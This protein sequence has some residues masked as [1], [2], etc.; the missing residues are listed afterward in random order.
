M[1]DAIHQPARFEA[2]NTDNILG[3]GVSVA[4]E[5]AAHQA[6]LGIEC[7]NEAEVSLGY[8][9]FIVKNSTAFTTGF[10]EYKGEIEGVGSA[11]NQFISG[12]KFFKPT[13]RIDE[14]DTGYAIW[15]DTWRIRII[16]SLASDVDGDF[17]DIQDGTIH[18]KPT[19]NQVDGGGRGYIALTSVGHIASGVKL[20]GD[21][22]LISDRVMD[23]IRNNA[24]AGEIKN[25][26][27][28]QGRTGGIS[29]IIQ[30]VGETGLLDFTQAHTGKGNLATKNAVDMDTA[31][32]LNKTAGNIT[33]TAGRKWAGETGANITETRTSANTSAVGSKSATQVGTG[34]DQ[35]GNADTDL[36]AL[37][38]TRGVTPKLKGSK[39]YSDDGVTV[40][41]STAGRLATGTTNK[42][43]AEVE[44]GVS[45]A[46][47]A[48][49]DLGALLQTRG[50]SPKAKASKI[51]S[52][53]GLLGVHNTDGTIKTFV[54]T[55]IINAL[56]PR[57]RVVNSDLEFWLTQETPNSWTATGNA[58]VVKSSTTKDAGSYSA[59][60]HRKHVSEVRVVL[61]TVAYVS[62]SFTASV[63]LWR[64]SGSGNANVRVRS[65]N[66]G[67]TQIAVYD[68]TTVNANSFTSSSIGAT[69][70]SGSTAFLEFSI[71]VNTNDNAFFVDTCSLNNGGEKLSNTGFETWTT[72]TTP[73]P[74]TALN[75]ATLAKSTS[76]FMGNYCGSITRA[77][78]SLTP[79]VKYVFDARQNIAGLMVSITGRLARVSGS[80]TAQLRV[81]ALSSVD[82]DLGSSAS[83]T[84]SATIYTPRVVNGYTLPSSTQKIELSIELSVN[85]D[86]W[87]FDTMGLSFTEV[88]QDMMSVEG[89]LIGEYRDWPWPEAD[90][91]F[92]W[93]LANGQVVNGIPTQDRRGWMPIGADGATYP[94]NET[95]GSATHNHGF[96][97]ATDGH[98][99]HGSAP[100]DTSSSLDSV[101][102]QSG[103]G[104]FVSA[105]YHIHEQGSFSPFTSDDANHAHTGTTDS[106]FALP[107]PWISTNWIVYIGS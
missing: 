57:N 22:G 50:A 61:Q 2:V 90:I 24:G 38:Q 103:T 63:K 39:V 16:V 87:L 20:G 59:L 95:G 1:S 53:D 28:V 64:Y 12:T 32:V 106:N 79:V 41:L 56:S 58:R 14:T 85:A 91:P 80:G 86:V 36:G 47:S 93:Y 8:R 37:L 99:Q 33:E 29:T 82:A 102:V 62:G 40:V 54:A 68:G 51:F 31:E 34:V 73:P 67:G 94:L 72:A 77:H 55:P 5:N 84:T 30:Y 27:I 65:L 23:V 26:A 89:N 19:V 100:F 74:W 88:A 4:V 21:L 17:D 97:T 25:T 52:D 70:P 96:T 75:G 35:A 46:A 10:I 98:H 78:A 71:A 66:S 105:D 81:R 15:F 45:Q 6:S 83:S 7:F 92:G 101:Q 44:T 107:V 69:T 49:T 104:E 76:A 9:W 18:I 3:L 48:D 43:V 11:D 60:C 13:A 42:T